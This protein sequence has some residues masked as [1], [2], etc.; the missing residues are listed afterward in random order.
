MNYLIISILP[1]YCDKIIKPIQS[2]E[3]HL[4]QNYKHYIDKY[5]EI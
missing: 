5:N 4:R 1:S 3:V 2:T